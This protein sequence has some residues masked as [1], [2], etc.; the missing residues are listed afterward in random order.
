MCLEPDRN[1][2][3]LIHIARSRGAFHGEKYA[4]C[5]KTN[6]QSSIQLLPA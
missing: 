6:E 1:G 5:R 4:A 2:V 3:I